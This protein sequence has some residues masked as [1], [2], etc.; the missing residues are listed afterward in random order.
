ML[1]PHQIT[2]DDIYA[3][4]KP[5]LSSADVSCLCIYENDDKNEQIEKLK[6]S[7]WIIC[8]SKRSIKS[9]NKVI[10]RILVTPNR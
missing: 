8:G 3:I 6:T 5:Y 1:T 9:L 4:A 2:K 10:S 7:K